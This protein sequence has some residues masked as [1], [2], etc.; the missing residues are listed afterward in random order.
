MVNPRWRI[1]VDWNDDGIWGQEVGAYREDVAAD[2][3][4]LDWKWGRPVNPDEAGRRRSE[5]A[6]LDL[7]LRNHD[8]R[9]T[10]GNAAS[11]LAGRVLVGR[12]VWASLAYPL[13][14]FKGAGEGAGRG[15]SGRADL[16]GRIPTLSD[17][18]AW[19]RRSTG[20]AG[21]VVDNGRAVPVAGT[22]SGGA[23]YTLD[24]RVADAH[25]GF[26][27]RRGSRV[28]D[29]SGG[30]A[31]SDGSSGV[32]LRFVNR[33]DYL[34]VRFDNA[35]TFLEDVTFGFASILRRGDALAAGVEYFIEIELH[36]SSVRLFA[37]DVR[38]GS[39]DRR[40]ILDGGGNAGNLSAT[41]HGIWHDGSAAAEA[42]RFGSFG[43]WRSFFHGHLSRIT[44]ERHPELGR[45]SRCQAR[46]D[47]AGPLR[48][49][50]YRLLTGRNLSTGAIANSLLSWAGFSSVHRRLDEGRTLVATEPRALWRLGGDAALN[51]LADEE[52]GSLYVDGRGYARLESASH[53]DGGPHTTALVTVRDTSSGGCYF[54]DLE[55]SDGVAGVENSVA[56]R[57][58]WGAS[59]G[60]Q[61]IWRLGGVTAIPA[62]ES[63]EFLAESDAFDAVDG[64]RV[65]VAET[66]YSANSRRDGRGEDLTGSLAVTLP[67]LPGMAG[68]PGRSGKSG[69]TQAAGNACGGRGTV[70]RVENRHATATAYVLLLRLRADHTY[71]A[72]ELTSYQARDSR[73]QARHGLRDSRVDCLFTDNYEAARAGAEARLSRT[74]AARRRLALTL[75]NG[76]ESNL[77]QV[78]HRVLADRVRVVCSDPVVDGDYFVEGME[79]SAVARTGSLA[80]RWLVE[81]AR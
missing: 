32:V 48:T 11:A 35:G 13:D 60:P 1:W 65:P 24:F 9:Y 22:G 73:S 68:T 57:Y 40:M 61:E 63:R 47:L 58:R 44:P 26:L 38:R 15:G 20:S 49:P 78:V 6:R 76:G 14:E 67:R 21:L 81:Q 51:A 2:V 72:T 29:S 79:I 18:Q 45:V 42:D 50:L 52:G 71:R 27:Y 23:I 53:R 41:S 74:G 62:G 64:I 59:Q 17:G 69:E 70:V 39:M 33:W 37:T 16:H 7:L 56:F 75:P 34:R 8:G 5:P 4:E 12:R 28:S 66:D 55:W 80:A 25:I 54:A 10:P 46:D 43:G 30:S 19:V 77:V 3:L 31:S 36:G